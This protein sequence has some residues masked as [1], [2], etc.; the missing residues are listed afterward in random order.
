MVVWGKQPGG[1]WKALCGRAHD[2][3]VKE[4]RKSIEGVQ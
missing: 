4:D 2:Y 1:A 3:T